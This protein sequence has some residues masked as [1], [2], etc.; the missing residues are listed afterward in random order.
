V[1]P[2]TPAPETAPALRHPGL[3]WRWV[4]LL[5]GGLFAAVVVA[6]W[7]LALHPATLWPPH[8]DARVFTWVMASLARRIFTNPWTLF[9]GNAFYPN[10]ESL[11]YSEPLMI[12]TL[13]GLPGFLW[14][15]PS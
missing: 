14:G 5:Y 10:G 15:N 3:G 6:T 9:H 13:L 2:P 12:P 11:A 4:A 1:S 7:P 8:H